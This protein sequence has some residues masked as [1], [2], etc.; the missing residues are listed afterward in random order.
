MKVL[1]PEARRQPALHPALGGTRMHPLSRFTE[2]QLRELDRRGLHLG[3]MPD[4]DF[5]VIQLQVHPGGGLGPTWIDFECP[6][7]ERRPTHT[8]VVLPSGELMASR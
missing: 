3:R 2:E 1:V 7:I 5:A 6:V 8:T 4:A